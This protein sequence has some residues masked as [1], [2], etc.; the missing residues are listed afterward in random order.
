MPPNSS[1][2]DYP[3]HCLSGIGISCSEHF[4]YSN[5]IHHCLLL[6]VQIPVDITETQSARMLLI[7]KLIS[8]LQN[9][10]A[11]SIPRLAWQSHSFRPR[12]PLYY[13]PWI[14]GPICTAQDASFHP[15]GIPVSGKVTKEGEWHTPSLHRLNVEIAH[16]TSTLIPLART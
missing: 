5:S 12:H 2:L 13:H 6:K 14:I 7:Q 16:I 3:F 1:S 11:I 10:L 4:I 8:P 15:V 9:Y